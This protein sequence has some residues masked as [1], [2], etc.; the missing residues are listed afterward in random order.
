MQKMSDRGEGVEE[1]FFPDKA[2][3]KRQ[4]FG[5]LNKLK[6]IVVGWF[7]YMFTPLSPMAKA[8]LLICRKCRFRK[9][10]FCGVCYCHLEA[11]AEVGWEECPKHFW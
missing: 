1:R 7:R 11:K 5:V 10:A 4:I 6:S 2:E 8:R 3:V 9:G